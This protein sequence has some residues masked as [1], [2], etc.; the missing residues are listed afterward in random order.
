MNDLMPR[1]RWP[2]IRHEKNRHGT[3]CWYFRKGDGPRIRL[4]DT[5]GSDEFKAAYDA[6][7]SGAPKRPAR[8]ASGSISWLVAR[9]RESGAFLHLAESTRYQREMHLKQ[10]VAG[11][12]DKPFAHVTKATIIAAMDK[13]AAT[14]HHANNML[15]ALSKL[16]EWAVANDHVKANPCD[17]VKPFKAKIIGHHPW[18]VEQVEQ[19]RKAHPVGTKAR[20]ALDLLLFTGLRRSDVIRAGKQHVRDG[21]LSYRTKKT[22]AWVHIPIFADLQT[23]IDATP[24]GDLTF[25]TGERGRQFA[26]PEVFGAWFRKQVEAAG[27][28]AECTAH[29]LRKAGATIAANAG[30]TAHELMAMFGWSRI[31]M[32][33]VYTK[34]ANKRRLAMGAAERIVNSFPPH[35]KSG[36]ANDGKL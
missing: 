12:G 25:L 27:L 16:F 36:A 2:H 19:Y 8:E 9:Y 31:S 5:F 10:M 22:G 32:A 29:G 34:E 1:P 13:R 33:E 17:G 30:A 15:T 18:S 21:V 11:A 23:S 28:P 35:P 4:P 20:L 7:L 6:A 26:S 14:P 24:T 3:W